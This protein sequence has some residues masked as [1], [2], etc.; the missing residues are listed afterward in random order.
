MKLIK[1]PISSRALGGSRTVWFEPG[2]NPAMP[3]CIFLDGEFYL[4]G[5]HVR[6]VIA[7][8]RKKGV[9]T[10]RRCVFVSHGGMEARTADFTCKPRYSRFLAGELTPTLTGTRKPPR[11]GHVIAGLSLG[12]LAAAF[13]ATRLPRAF[14]RWIVQSPSAWWKNEWLGRRPRREMLEKR[15]AR[16]S[17]VGHKASYSSRKRHHGLTDVRLNVRFSHDRDSHHPST[18]DALPVGRQCRID[19]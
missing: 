8:M 9:L 10:D 14:P 18:R 19:P 7:A 12:G 16:R 17:S 13:A 1:Q 2:E 5:L 3:L 11:D 15:A 4:D 6:K